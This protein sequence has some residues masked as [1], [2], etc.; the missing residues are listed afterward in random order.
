MLGL[1]F[2]IVNFSLIFTIC[3]PIWILWLP[4]HPITANYTGFKENWKH[5]INSKWRIQDGRWFQ[6]IRDPAAWVIVP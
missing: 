4:K 6:I 3:N 5:L 2:N 1:V